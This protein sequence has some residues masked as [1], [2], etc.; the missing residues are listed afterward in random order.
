MENARDMNGLLK[1]AFKLSVQIFDSLSPSD[2]YVIVNIAKTTNSTFTYPANS[3]I[4]TSYGYLFDK[5]PQV[6]IE[7]KVFIVKEKNK[8]WIGNDKIKQNTLDLI[9][10]M[11]RSKGYLN[12]DEWAHY[13][14]QWIYDHYNYGPTCSGL[15]VVLIDVLK[16]KEFINKLSGALPVFNEATKSLE[17]LGQTVLFSG[18]LR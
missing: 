14:S 10:I 18:E 5:T 17:F 4:P 3:E 15:Y 12:K 11:A 13:Y 1:D 7:E 9:T 16:L 6:L 2:K 8:W